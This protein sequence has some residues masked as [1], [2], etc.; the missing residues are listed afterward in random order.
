[1]EWKDCGNWRRLIKCIMETQRWEQK[2]RD[3]VPQK[4]IVGENQ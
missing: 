3:R 2:A 1:M 4:K